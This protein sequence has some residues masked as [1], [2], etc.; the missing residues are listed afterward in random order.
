MYRVHEPPDPEKLT[1]LAEFVEGL[2]LR[3]EPGRGEAAPGDIQ[4][5]LRQ[6]EGRP[7]YPVVAQVALRS[8]KQA[9]Y[10]TDNVGH[11]GLA[12]PIYCHFTSPIRRYPDLVVHRLLRARRDRQKGRLRQIAQGLEGVAEACS[13]LERNA[14]SA[15]RELLAW[16]AVRF[17]SD[18]VGDTLDGVVVGVAPFGLFVRLTETLVEGLVRVESLGGEWFEHVEARQELRGQNSGRSY[19]LGQAMRVRVVKVDTVLRRVDLEPAETGG[20]GS[21]PPEARPRGRRGG[22]ARRPG[23]GRPARGRG[24]RR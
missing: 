6:A 10:A 2:G 21:A 3:F 15:E 4:R 9:R 11:F 1:T 5:L 14:E 23:A 13:T 12:A 7:E 18:R 8:M 17:M 16:K 19:R 24:R 22:R 20:K